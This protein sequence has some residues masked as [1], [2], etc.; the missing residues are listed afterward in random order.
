MNSPPGDFTTADSPTLRPASA[1]PIGEDR[2]IVAISSLFSSV[3]E[4]TR[5][6]SL[7]SP[8][9]TVTI[10]PA[11]TISADA[12]PSRTTAFFKMC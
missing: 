10:T 1:R 11:S 2:V 8:S 12:G 3:D 6:S 7:W 5:Y 4:A 9:L